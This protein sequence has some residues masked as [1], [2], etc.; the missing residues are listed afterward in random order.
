[1]VGGEK[2][3][4]AKPETFMNESGRSVRELMSWYKCEHRELIVVYDDM[5]LPPGSLRIR[6]GG[7]AGT[8]NG[9]RSIIYQLGYDDFPRV[10]VGIG[11]PAYNP[12]SHVLSAPQGEER[13]NLAAAMEKAAEAVE[14]IV[15]GRL[16]E[17]QTRFNHKP[18]KNSSIEPEAG[19]KE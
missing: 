8:H 3:I 10:R 16:G 2:V 18:H 13:E 7:S 4:L 5:D 1:M 9:M 15:R 14:L 11:E 12:V 17:A 6:E 19:E